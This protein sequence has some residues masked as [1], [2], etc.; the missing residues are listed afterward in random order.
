MKQPG[1]FYRSRAETAWSELAWRDSCERRIGK[2]RAGRAQKESLYGRK[3]GTRVA[4][5]L[6][7]KCDKEA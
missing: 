1:K 6:C 5:V 2:V 7:L 4:K 3:C